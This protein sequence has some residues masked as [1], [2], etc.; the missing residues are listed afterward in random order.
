MASNVIALT[1]EAGSGKTEVANYLTYGH[2]FTPVKFA[3]PLKAMLAAF[4]REV[5]LDDQEIS[6]RLEGHLKE[7]PDAYL[8]GKTP[9]HAMETLG[10]EWGRVAIH[11]DLW[12][13]AWGAKVNRVKGA[14][15]V[16]DCRF[17]NE[18]E[19]SRAMVGTVVKLVP[20]V[21]RR[22]NSKHV[23]ENGVSPHLIDHVIKN[24]D[25]I[26]KLRASIDALLYPIALVELRGRASTYEAQHD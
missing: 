23:A 3:G 26:G 21:K 19:L 5:G 25:G 14:V 20:K 4:Y 7:V 22:K 11:G 6:D 12:I 1:G 17:D 10:T 24:D 9:R 2:G 13:N 15:V 16:D 8:M 18:A